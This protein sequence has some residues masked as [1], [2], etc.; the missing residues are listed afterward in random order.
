MPR[1]TLAPTRVPGCS[2]ASA[3]C[4]GHGASCTPS[5]SHAYVKERRRSRAAPRP[6]PGAGSVPAGRMT[7]RCPRCPTPHRAGARARIDRCRA[8][9][10]SRCEFLRPGGHKRPPACPRRRTLVPGRARLHLGRFPARAQC[11]Q[12]PPALARCGGASAGRFLL[13]P[14]SAPYNTACPPSSSSAFH[15]HRTSSSSKLVD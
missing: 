7:C 4:A 9:S 6:E 11:A 10:V 15:H 14:S 13:C 1:V 2:R 12:L 5:R 3:H 8:R